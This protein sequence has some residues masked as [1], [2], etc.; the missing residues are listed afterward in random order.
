MLHAKFQDNR[1]SGSGEEDFLKVFTIYGHGGHLGH[2]TCNISI[3]FHPH[4]PIR[5]H[6]KFGQLVSEK[7]MFENNVYI[8][9]YSPRTGADNPLG[10]I[11]SLTV[12]FSQYSP[13]LQV[14]L[15]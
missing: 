7:E 11:F 9:V 4:F 6:M 14:F 1:T 2:V 5:I 13:L 15:Y 10:S 8:H 3:S 12:L